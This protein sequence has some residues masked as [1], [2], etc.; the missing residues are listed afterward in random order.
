MSTPTLFGPV[1][2]SFGSHWSE[3]RRSW[4]IKTLL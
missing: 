4:R 1:I 3:T 2:K